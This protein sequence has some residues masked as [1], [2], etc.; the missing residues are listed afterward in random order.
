MALA[1]GLVGI[2]SVI[3]GLF[4]SLQWDVPAGP[5]VVVAAVA[6]FGI[7]TALSSAR[8]RWAT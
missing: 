3:G 4:A 2:V 6:V 8:G 7:A 5:A 1:A